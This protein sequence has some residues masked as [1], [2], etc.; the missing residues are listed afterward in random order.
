MSQTDNYLPF[1]PAPE[2]K[3]A[4]PVEIF[5]IDSENIGGCLC[6]TKS[7]ITKITIICIP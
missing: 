3:S 1:I 2:G 7:Q 4:A 6:L 5:N